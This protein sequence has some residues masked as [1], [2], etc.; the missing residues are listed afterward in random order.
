MTHIQRSALLPY[1][2]SHLYN[3]VNRVETFIRSFCPWCS[4]ATVLSETDTE[5]CA[6]LDIAKA[7]MSQAFTT[8]QCFGAGRAHYAAS[9][10]WPVQR[11]SWCLGVQGAW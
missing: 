9:G 10:G 6:R 3:L 4:G 7:G 1:P 8:P 11:F 2:A 5:M